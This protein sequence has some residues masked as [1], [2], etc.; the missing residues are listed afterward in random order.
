LSGPYTN[1]AKKVERFDLPPLKD[2]SGTRLSHTKQMPIN[3]LN[4]AMNQRQQTDSQI[5][6]LVE[7]RNNKSLS[8]L[9]KTLQDRNRSPSPSPSPE[10]MMKTGARDNI[11]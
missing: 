10:P 4:A 9:P 2:K 7:S 11:K 8:P 1:I 5:N 6:L 3:L